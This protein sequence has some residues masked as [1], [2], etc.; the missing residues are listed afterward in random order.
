MSRSFEVCL[1]CVYVCTQA[2]KG[3]LNRCES[4]VYSQLAA[5]FLNGHRATQSSSTR[6][7]LG[8]L[9]QYSK[10]EVLIIF[11]PETRSIPD[12]KTGFRV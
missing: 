9:L 8:S 7:L 11:D 6:T 12:I 4:K 3:F 1:L 5:S 2:L 10:S